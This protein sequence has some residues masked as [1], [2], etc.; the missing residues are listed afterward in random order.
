MDTLN[1]LITSSSWFTAS[2]LGYCLLF[3]VLALGTGMG[4]P[5]QIAALSA[6]MLFGIKVGFGIA[7]LATITGCILTFM[8]SRYLLADWV[9]K[10]F[11]DKSLLVHEFLSDSTFVKAL[12]IRILPL[13]SNFVTNI[14]A[15]ATRIPF[16]PYVAGSALGFIPQMV[17]FTLAGG[18]IKLASEQQ[19]QLTAVLVVI[20]CLLGLFLWL[21]KRRQKRASKIKEENM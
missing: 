21:A 12:I 17:V 5:R 10:R 16:A 20:A 8:V 15:G 7:T 18:G 4:L 3:V 6:G 13:G 19:S 11:P 1:H 2:P 14:I 9:F